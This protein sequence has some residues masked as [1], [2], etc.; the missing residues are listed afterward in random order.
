LKKEKVNDIPKND[1]EDKIY[2]IFN[3]Q[4]LTMGDKIVIIGNTGG[5]KS[6]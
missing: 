1:C 3:N 4:G 5:G 2:Q 6:E